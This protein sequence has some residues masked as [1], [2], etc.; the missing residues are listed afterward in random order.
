M[1]NFKLFP[2]NCKSTF[3]V[4]E[5]TVVPFLGLSGL[6]GSPGKT[7]SPGSPCLLRSHA[8][9]CSPGSLVE[10]GLPGCPGLSGTPYIS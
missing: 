7:G 1:S 8:L 10:L 4:Q 5:T 3:S 2:D 6:A 9:S